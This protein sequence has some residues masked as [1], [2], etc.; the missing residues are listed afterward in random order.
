[1]Y[2]NVRKD[3]KTC[4]ICQQSKRAF[5]AK[6]PPLQPQAVDD[7]FSRWQ[8]GILSGLP[9]TKEKY[10]PVLLVVDSSSEWCECF[11]LRTQ[12]A[13]VVAAVLVREILSRYGAPRVLI[14][15]RR[16]NFMSNLVKAL[17]ELFEIKRNY[18]SAYHPMSNRLVESKNSTCLLQRSAK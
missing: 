17:S 15:D 9:T 11:P 13:T 3:V 16:K 10:K 2:E 12:D 7:V 14:S 4:K 6:P 8:I 1:M 18:T 5:G